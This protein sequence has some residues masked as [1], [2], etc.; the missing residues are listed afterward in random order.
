MGATGAVSVVVSD[1]WAV[2]GRD[3]GDMVVD[4]Q[5]RGVDF[6]LGCGA[7]DNRISFPGIGQGVSTGRPI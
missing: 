2:E 6:S 3:G 4:G 5:I 1:E 7:S